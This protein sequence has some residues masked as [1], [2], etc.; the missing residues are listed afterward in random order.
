MSKINPFI[1]FLGPEDHLQ[2]QVIMW[3]KFQYP[4]LKYHH[5]PDASRRSPFERFKYEYL[6]SDAGYL[7]L[8]FPSLLLA[9]E[10]KIKPNKV[11]PSQT[12]WI[13]YLNKH[14][15]T[16]DVCFTFDQACAMINGAVERFKIDAF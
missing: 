8:T 11:T 7:D 2:H 4:N 9:I 13:E 6:G 12:E 1:K 16:A 14:G 15:W 5:S 3:L 10:L